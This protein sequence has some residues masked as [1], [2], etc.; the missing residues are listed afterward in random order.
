MPVGKVLHFINA[1]MPESC[2]FPTGLTVLKH[3]FA[4]IY[5][6]ISYYAM[7]FILY[8]IILYMI[9]IMLHYSISHYLPDK[10]IYCRT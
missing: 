10:A 5:Y 1:V 4:Q 7:L 2:S 3:S 9:Y 8:Y 6:I